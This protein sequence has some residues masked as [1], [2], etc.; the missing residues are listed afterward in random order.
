MRGVVGVVMVASAGLVLAACGGSGDDLADA[1]PR[2]R[3][4]AVVAVRT[5]QFR[6]GDLRVDA[7]T[8]VT[9]TNRDEILHTVTAEP[10]SA[11]AGESFDGSLDGA[12]VQFTHRFTK[13]GEY[14]YGCARHPAM[15]GRVVVS[16]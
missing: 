5:F 9:W 4:R 3:D 10:A 8:R 6:P 2:A 7:G 14:P 1:P 16:R 11:A 15:R 13:A 12:D